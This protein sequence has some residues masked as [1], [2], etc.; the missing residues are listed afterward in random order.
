MKRIVSSTG[1]RAFRLVGALKRSRLHFPNLTLDTNDL[2]ERIKRQRS[3]RRIDRPFASS[4]DLLP[5]LFGPSRPEAFHLLAQRL[6]FYRH[7]SHYQAKLTNFTNRVTSSR[8]NEDDC[9]S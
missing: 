6:D 1:R 2:E 7:L 9:P 8:S 5:P 4:G 3:F